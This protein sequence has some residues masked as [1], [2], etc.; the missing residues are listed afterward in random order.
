MC[1][2]I[3]CLLKFEHMQQ[4][5]GE[6]IRGHVCFSDKGSFSALISRQLNEQF[7]CRCSGITPGKWQEDGRCSVI[8]DEKGPSVSNTL[9]TCTASSKHPVINGSVYSCNKIPS[10]YFKSFFIHKTWVVKL[11]SQYF[12]KYV[13]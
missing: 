7:S 11:S 1:Q 5:T 13:V 10:M 9:G 4:D 2:S 8:M 3:L 12:S 6:C